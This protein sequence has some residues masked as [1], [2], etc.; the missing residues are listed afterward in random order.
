MPP[1]RATRTEVQAMPFA[2]TANAQAAQARRRLAP[3]RPGAARLRA[4]D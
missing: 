3:G 4:T 2:W 1:P